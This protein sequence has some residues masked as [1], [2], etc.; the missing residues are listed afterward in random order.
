[1]LGVEIKHDQHVRLI[2]MFQWAYINSIIQ[3]YNFNDLKPLLMPMD[4]ITCL[5]TNQSPAS[6]I[7]HTI[8]HD[9]PYCKAVGALNWAALATCPNIAFTVGIV[10]RFAANPRIAH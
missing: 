4:P 10:M 1:M 2:H 8:M 3:C 7:E 5:T 9:K 6:A